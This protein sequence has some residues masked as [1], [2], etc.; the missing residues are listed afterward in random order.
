VHLL[1]LWDR[2]AP[3][4]RRFPVLTYLLGRVYADGVFDSRSDR[5]DEVTVG[6]VLL[7]LARVLCADRKGNSLHNRLLGRLTSLL[8]GKRGYLVRPLKTISREELANYLGI[9][10]RHGT[11]QDIQNFPTCINQLVTAIR[12][13][14]GEPNL[15]VLI[16]GYEMAAT[17]NLAPTSSFAQ[18]II[19]RIAMIPT[20]V[21][22]SAVVP[23]D[24]PNIPIEV[25]PNEPD[26]DH[27]FTLDGHKEYVKRLLQTMQD[28]GWRH[29]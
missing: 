18:Q 13:D 14:V 20:T 5:P 2:V 28:K 21:S 19:P 27:H 1:D 15:P 12:N 11:A 16:N 23:T 25:E 26:G 8:T 10:E 29:W 17:R 7:H 24:N 9:T 22:N 4:P 3:Y 6:R